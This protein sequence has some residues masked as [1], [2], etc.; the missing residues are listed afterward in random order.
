[1][2]PA[3]WVAVTGQMV[4]EDVTYIVVMATAV[5]VERVVTVAMVVGTVT[6][7]VV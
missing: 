3:T 7:T 1:M 4:V 2:L 6:G 5:E